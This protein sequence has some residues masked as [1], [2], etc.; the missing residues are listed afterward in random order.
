[1]PRRRRPKSARRARIDFVCGRYSVNDDELQVLLL[2]AV[3]DVLRAKQCSTW[4]EYA[5]VC[6]VS[7]ARMLE[8]WGEEISR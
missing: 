2:E 7:W 5:K 4:G 1:M 3:Q 8:D 6:G